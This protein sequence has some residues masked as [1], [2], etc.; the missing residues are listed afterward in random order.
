MEHD[1]HELSERLSVLEE[2]MRT[3]HAEYETGLARIEAEAAKRETRMLIAIGGLIA[4]GVVVLGVLIRL[5]G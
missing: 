1:G 4:L 2:R 3:M 5:P